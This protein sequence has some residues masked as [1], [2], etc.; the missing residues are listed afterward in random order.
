[1]SYLV[2]QSRI[3]PTKSVRFGVTKYEALESIT[4]GS[5][6]SFLEK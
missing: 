4:I 6:P 1:L 5:S 2:E 3:G